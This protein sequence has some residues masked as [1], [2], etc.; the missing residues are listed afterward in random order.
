MAKSS[1]LQNLRSRL[2]SWRQAHAKARPAPAADDDS[3]QPVLSVIEGRRYVNGL[4]WRLIPPTRSL[5]RTLSLARK[6]NKKKYVLTDMEDIIGVC[7]ALPNRWSH[8]Y[9]AALHLATRM[10][11]GGL[12]LYAFELTNRQ[13]MVVALNETRPIPGFDFVGEAE[14]ARGLMDEFMAIQQ[15]QP[16]RLVGNAGWL[17]GEESVALE[18]IFNAPERSARLKFLWGDHSVKWATGIALVLVAG[19]AGGQYWVEME[20]EEMLAAASVSASDPN[21]DYQKSL[22]QAWAEVPAPGPGLLQQWQSL[23]DQLPVAHRGWRLET[24]SCEATACQAKWSRIHGTY[25]DF[26]QQLPP[27]TASAQEVLEGEDALL[28]T[29]VSTHPVKPQQPLTPWR[30]AVLPRM[31]QALREHASQLQNLSLLGQ[32]KVTM[33]KPSLFGGVQDPRTLKQA[34]MSG[35]WSVQHDAS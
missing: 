32:V 35:Q 10:S 15:G 13:S 34:V 21:A 16:M 19:V 3:V 2:Q 28:A 25:A 22:A 5:P 14:Q 17:E 20:R 11:Q 7:G 33:G 29:V 31:D 8:V 9:S 26:F 30:Q 24:V 1:I 18:D 23:L 12:E 27:N 6:E 4:E